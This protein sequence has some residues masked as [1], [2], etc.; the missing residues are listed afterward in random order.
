MEK[1]GAEQLQPKDNV[2]KNNVEKKESTEKKECFV[3]GNCEFYTDKIEDI[4]QE[5][6]R[7]VSHECPNCASSLKQCSFEEIDE[8]HCKLEKLHRKLEKKYKLEFLDTSY[9][10]REDCEKCRA[11]KKDQ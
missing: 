2:E 8:L 3:C 9:T 5:T 11:L 6:S 10:I 1:I 7:G 4:H